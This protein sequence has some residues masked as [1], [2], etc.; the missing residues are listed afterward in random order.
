M[1]TRT[2]LASVSLLA[3][4]A[5]AGPSSVAEDAAQP[6]QAGLIVIDATV[7]ARPPEMPLSEAPAA[8]EAPVAAEA[9]AADAPLAE[10]AAPAEDPAA[11]VQEARRLLAGT[12]APRDPAGAAGL[13]ERAAAAGNAGAA[14]MLGNLYRA[15]D[16]VTADPER[17][18]SLYEQAV[19]AGDIRGAAYGLGALY[20][21]GPL[22]DPAQ[23]VGYFEQSA[24]AGNTGA[25]LV[26]GDMYRAGEGVAADPLRA[27]SY[28]EQALA[29]GHEDASYGLGLLYREE[30]LRDPA[31]AIGYLTRAA[32]AGKPN[33]LIV[34]G[35]IFRRGDGVTADP[36]TAMA[37]YQQALDAG[38]ER[39][40]A[41]GMGTL[42]R[43]APYDDAAQAISW[44]ERA[45]AAGNPGAL[46]TLG[47]IWRS[48]EGVEP[49]AERAKAFYEAALA[50]GSEQAASYGLGLLYSDGPLRDPETA[51]TYLQRASE[52]GS[53]W[54]DLAFAQLYRDDFSDPEKVETMI[55]R[56]R[57]AAVRLGSGRVAASILGG[58]AR[59]RTATLQALLQAAGGDPGPID[60]YIGPR[61]VRALH[62]FCN[63]NDIQRCNAD[64]PSAEVVARL[65]EAG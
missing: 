30:P 29:A 19:A 7:P 8:A 39:A 21:A 46:V 12:D 9:P 31:A 37:Y 43:D 33:A 38:A 34:L 54:A 51:A 55:A 41:Y 64:R 52:A 13:L 3:L 56:Y 22:A 50:A 27:K 5:L 65:L 11:L 16:G 63:A 48:G 20:R 47:D 60:G 49:D 14:T 58:E 61:T 6:G 59:P 2:I 1:M 25:A 42:Y 17:A 62:G 44:F 18:R 15:G 36:A 40:A 32:A 10:A 4:A 53:G 28:Y 23:A 24:G 26:L 45:A 35:D 57:D